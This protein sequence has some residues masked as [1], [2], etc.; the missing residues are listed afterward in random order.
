MRGAV[1]GLFE[2]TKIGG[3]AGFELALR[4]KLAKMLYIPF[5]K[6]TSRTLAL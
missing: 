1:G 3:V 2:L 6:L 4:Y 5:V